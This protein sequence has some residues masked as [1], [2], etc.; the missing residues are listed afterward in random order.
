MSV[1][2]PF[3]PS[4]VTRAKGKLLPH[5]NVTLGTLCFKVIAVRVSTDT[6][7]IVFAHRGEVAGS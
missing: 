3:I 1:C 6:L 4:G 5:I 7:N 2:H